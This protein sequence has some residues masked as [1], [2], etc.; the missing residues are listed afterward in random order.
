MKRLGVLFLLIS[1]SA[2]FNLINYVGKGYEAYQKG[3]LE[4][5]EQYFR[6]TVKRNRDPDRTQPGCGLMDL[7]YR[8]GDSAFEVRRGASKTPWPRPTSTWRGPTTNRGN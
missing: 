6:T 4:T 2:C 3:D 7:T 5:A 8:R 1:L